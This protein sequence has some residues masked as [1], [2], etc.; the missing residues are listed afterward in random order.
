MNR[1]TDSTVDQ[2]A[3]WLSVARRTV[4][5][6]GAGLSKASGIPTYRDAGG[7]WTEGNQ[8]RF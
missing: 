3:N 1:S 7:L 6:S 4:V 2:V 8:L 5:L